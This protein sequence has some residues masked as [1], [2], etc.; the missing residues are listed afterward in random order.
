MLVGYRELC[1]DDAG[2][3]CD[4]LWDLCLSLLL[5][6]FLSRHVAHGVGNSLL[7]YF[8]ILFYGVGFEA[9]VIRTKKKKGE[10]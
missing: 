1:V 4:Q 7:F 10:K 5:C 8:Y 2:L 9:V 6:G 3:T